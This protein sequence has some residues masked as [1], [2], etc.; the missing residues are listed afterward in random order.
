VCASGENFRRNNLLDDKVKFIKGWFRDTLHVA[1]A[2]SSL[3]ISKILK[4]A[5]VQFSNFASGTTSSIPCRASI[6]QR[7]FGVNPPKPQ[8]S[9]YSGHATGQASTHSELGWLL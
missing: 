6:G 4:L 2:L 8:Q 1:L 3:M 9:S 5:D 7:P